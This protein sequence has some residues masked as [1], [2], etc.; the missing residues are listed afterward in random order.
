[1]LCGTELSL[2]ATLATRRQYKAPDWRVRGV[3]SL[4]SQPVLS[5]FYGAAGSRRSG[6]AGWRSSRTSG[7]AHRT[8]LRRELPEVARGFLHKRNVLC[9]LI[10]LLYQGV[11]LFERLLLC[12]VSE[13]VLNVVLER[14]DP[15]LCRLKLFGKL[16]ERI[17]TSSLNLTSDTIY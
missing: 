15:G 3:I 13:R 1:M 12:C 7:I 11:A 8:L 14:F 4:S 10:V 17:P 2:T 9:Q 6:W 16:V 5:H